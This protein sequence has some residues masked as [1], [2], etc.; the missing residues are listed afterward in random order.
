[1]NFNLEPN[2]EPKLEPNTYYTLFYCVMH[3]IG[4]VIQGKYEYAPEFI[5]KNKPCGFNSNCEY[6]DW[7]NKGI[8]SFDGKEVCILS[9]MIQSDYCRYG[10]GFEFDMY[11][12]N[13]LDMENKHIDSPHPLLVKWFREFESKI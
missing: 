9:D 10:G 4:F 3:D 2:L 13:I 11:S 8:I 7:Y 1:M 12:Y 6:L 5:T